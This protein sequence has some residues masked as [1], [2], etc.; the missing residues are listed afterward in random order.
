MSNKV[1]DYVVDRKT[2]LPKAFK[3]CLEMK[4]KNVEGLSEA[5]HVTKGRTWRIIK[6]GNLES[7]KIQLAAQYFGLPVSK[8]CAKGE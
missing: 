3:A 8:F 2:D 1:K 4:G 6:Q 7:D 5:L